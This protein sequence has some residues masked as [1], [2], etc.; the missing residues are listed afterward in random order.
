MFSPLSLGE[1]PAAVALILALWICVNRIYLGNLPECAAGAVLSPSLSLPCFL[2]P[3]FSLFLPSSPNINPS[4]KV[5]NVLFWSL[6][7]FINEMNAGWQATDGT[8]TLP[9]PTPTVSHLIECRVFFW[10]SH[11]DQSALLPQVNRKNESWS[12]RLCSWPDILLSLQALGWKTAVHHWSYCE[13]LLRHGFMRNSFP[14]AVRLG[15]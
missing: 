11:T 13:I 4:I 12:L 2:Y 8:K 6:P 3:F 1:S 7:V 5:L 15:G 14:Q 10:M 9:N